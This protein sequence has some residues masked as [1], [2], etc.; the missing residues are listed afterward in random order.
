MARWNAGLLSLIC[1]PGKK[2]IQRIVD[3]FEGRYSM[4]YSSEADIVPFLKGLAQ[5]L[6]PYAQANDV[7]ISFSSGLKKQV[8][9]YQPS[10][11]SQSFVQLICNIIN[12]LPPKSKIKVRLFYSQDDQ[13][14]QIEIENTSINL[15]RVIE[16]TAQTTYSF[17]G[18]PLSH[19]TLYRLV[20]PLKDQ[21]STPNQLARENSSSSN[22]PQFYREIQKRLNSHF[23]Q[24]EKL[25]AT[26]EQSRPHEAAFMQKINTLIKVNLENENF[27]SNAL[28][29]AMSMSRTQLFRRLK[30]LIRQAP[31]IY[32]KTIRL[33]RAKEM[34]ETSDWT[35][36]EIAYKT[37]FQTVSHFTKI[38]KKQYGIPPSVFRR[39]N[40][41]ATN[42]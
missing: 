32:I 36:S 13:N 5:S 4:I 2:G 31:A 19:G 1:L 16:V 17:T 21:A 33:Q 27:D 18:H 28:C 42:E 11:L 24:T 8:V 22:L 29:K 34:L 35:V 26:L 38:F 10:L 37:G 20:L 3:N 12:L 6:Q 30:S 7:I 25:L 15:M 23:T 9:L 14:L 40:K 41:S 39:A